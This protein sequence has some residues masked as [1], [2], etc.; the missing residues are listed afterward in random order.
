MELDSLDLTQQ[1]CPMALL[2]AKR[3]CHQLQLKQTTRIYT[4]NQA[5]TLDI[6]SYLMQNSFT[7]EISSLSD[8]YQLIISK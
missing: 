7:I 1:R 3:H 4:Q 8:C 2:L 5:S 6:I